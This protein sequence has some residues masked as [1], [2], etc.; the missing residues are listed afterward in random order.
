LGFD[1]KIHRAIS[2]QIY[3]KVLLDYDDNTESSRITNRE[4]AHEAYKQVILNYYSRIP[5]QVFIEKYTGS[6]SRLK[7]EIAMLEEQ[8]AALYNS[9][10]WR[11]TMPLR[12]IGHQVKRFRRVAELT[13]P[14]IQRGGG[15]E[16]H[17]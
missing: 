9:T 17:D 4:S 14:A 12:F 5:Q 6:T 7:N 8:I 13:K 16:Q 10:S 11:I 1:Y 15:F 3:T 2:A